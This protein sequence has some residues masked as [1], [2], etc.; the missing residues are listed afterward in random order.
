MVSIII[1]VY[2]VD[3]YI[4]ECL[5]SCIS[6]IYKDIEIVVVNDGSTDS[7][8]DII[9]KYAKQ[10]SRIK[11]YNQHNSGVVVARELGI[12][13]SEGEY[14][15]FVDSDDFIAP[16]MISEMLETGKNYDIVACDFYI[17]DDITQKKQVRRNYYL[18]GSKNEIINSLLSRTCTWSLCGKL[19][20]RH[21][22]STVNMPY[23]VKS[24]EDGIV[25]FQLHNNAQNV[26]HIASSF[27]YY[28]QRASSVT[29]IR[30]VNISQSV[31]EFILY[32]ERL[33][34][35]YKWSNNTKKYL[36]SFIL[37]QIYV[38]YVNGGSLI[39]LKERID[40]NFSIGEIMSSN[41][42][43]IEKIGVILFFKVNWLS[44]FIR[45]VYA[46]I[47]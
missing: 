44:I 32:I 41:L 29:H 40:V 26:Y 16:N 39:A 11:V 37:S 28:R 18:G 43:A 9:S 36:H 46:S 5:E 47:I 21:L 34:N 15:C 45:Q 2:N 7:S 17:Y 14:L 13:K 31:I 10:D 6:Q 23:G 30:S 24:G 3:K 35:Q 38:Y 22:F 1:P 19:F 25:C 12:E 4:R 27:Y 42:S 8:M 20:K 33:N